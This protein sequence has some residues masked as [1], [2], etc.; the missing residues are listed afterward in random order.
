MRKTISLTVL[1]ISLVFFYCKKDH[2]IEEPEPVP[3]S[4]KKL[5]IDA[6]L[7]NLQIP[8]GM[9]ELPNGDLLFSERSGRI[10]LLKK[11]ETQKKN[12]YT[13]QVQQNG[14]G[15]ML[16]ICIDPLFST[17]HYVYAYETTDSNRIVRFKLEN[18]VLT[19][20]KVILGGIPQAQNHDG[21]ALKFGPDGYLYVGTG[22]VTQGT[23]AQDKNSLAGK[24]LRIDRE[25]A[26]VSGN[27][28]NS[29]IWTY[30][31]RNV[32]G[33]T[34]TH[35]GLMLATEHGPSGE[36]GWI[37]HDEINI[38]S[39]GKNYGWPL[40]RAGTETDSL[41][42]PLIHS[43][44]DTWAPSGCVWLGPSSIWPN[45]L[46]VGALRGKR[47]LRIYIDP[48]SKQVISQKDTLSGTFNRLR[49]IIE[50]QDGSLIFGSS[51]VGTQG[52]ELPEDDKIYKLHLK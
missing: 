45:C 40:A 1:L 18:D 24:I 32:Q 20:D 2:K 19:K 13:G 12:L 29:R 3:S 4:P 16:G 17:N 21:G 38:I 47:L 28:F 15:G 44:N 50:N 37:A 49:N 11:N 34:W 36:S 52:S 27:P 14:E 31:H 5:V 23:L 6:L 42:P 10:N 39:P 26:P 46:V 35:T 8:W 51:N 48:I 22:D 9:A 41:T 30:G 33:I 25:G 43:G 7:T